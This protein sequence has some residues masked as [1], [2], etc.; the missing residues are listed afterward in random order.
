[1]LKGGPDPDMGY[2]TQRGGS[3]WWP[4]TVVHPGSRTG[5]C[6]YGVLVSPRG[7]VSFYLMGAK[8]NRNTKKCLVNVFL[9]PLLRVL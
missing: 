8:W 2:T 9:I 5:M 3:G 1:M 7:M 4:V 6:N